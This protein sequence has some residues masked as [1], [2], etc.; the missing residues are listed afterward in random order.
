MP[1]AVRQPAVEHRD[2]GPQ[3]RDAPGGLCGEAGLADDLDVAVGLE[4]ILEPA[5]DHL[6]VVEQE[7]AD[8]AVGVGIVGHCLSLRPGAGKRVVGPTEE[9]RMPLPDSCGLHQ[10]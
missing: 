6:V 9:G 3:R 2:V 5:A 10:T 1:R 4:Q 8:R 7:H